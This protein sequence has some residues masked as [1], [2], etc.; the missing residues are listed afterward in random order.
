MAEQLDLSSPVVIPQRSTSTWAV[1]EIHLLRR[2]PAVSVLIESNLGERLEVRTTSEPEALTLLSQLNT[3]NLTVKSLQKR[4]LEWCA[5][6]LG[7]LAGTVSG[8]PE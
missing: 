7:A 2:P 3:A 8:T 6:K 5:S 4:A 1:L